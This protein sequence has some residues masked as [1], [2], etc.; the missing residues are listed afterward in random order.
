MKLKPMEAG[1]NDPIGVKFFTAITPNRYLTKEID[2]PKQSALEK[3]ADVG[4]NEFGNLFWIELDERGPSGAVTFIEDVQAQRE[5]ALEK[6][7]QIYRDASDFNQNVDKNQERFRHGLVVVKCTSTII[8]AGLTLPFIPGAA[9]GMAWAAAGEIGIFSGLGVGASYGIGLELVKNW[10]RAEESD[11]VLVAKTG[12]EESFKKALDVGS[13]KGAKALE[14][15]AE[16]MAREAALHIKW[17]SKPLKGN[18]TIA[19]ILKRADKLTAARK[20]AEMSKN[21]GRLTNALKVVPYLVFAWSAGSALYDAH[22][23]W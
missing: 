22:E 7:K 17:L 12:G 5:N 13:E 4:A 10:D 1:P 15:K 8:V 11:V 14:P 2:L 18:P 23:E 6:V 9:A 19:K 20:A 16:E 3:E 21:L